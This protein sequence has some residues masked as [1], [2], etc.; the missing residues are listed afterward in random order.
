MADLFRNP[1][2]Y[3]VEEFIEPSFRAKSEDALCLGNVGRP[4]LHVIFVGRIRNVA[5]RLRA[6]MNFFPNDAAEF[7]YRCC[8]GS[9]EIEILVECSGMFDAHPNAPGQIAS[10]SVMTHLA[11]RAQ[12]VKRVLTL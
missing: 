10:I 8:D 12:D 1:R 11:S 9:G 4:H 3:F 2:D 7:D 6:L 5:E